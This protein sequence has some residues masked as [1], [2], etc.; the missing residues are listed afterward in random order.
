MADVEALQSAVASRPKHI[1]TSISQSMNPRFKKWID[2]G[3][4]ALL[5]SSSGEPDKQWQF[6]EVAEDTESLWAKGSVGV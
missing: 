6:K 2:D 1:Y 3:E 5:F 4:S